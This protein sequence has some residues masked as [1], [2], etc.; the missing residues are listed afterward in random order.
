MTRRF[1]EQLS[2]LKVIIVVG[3]ACLAA[4]PLMCRRRPQDEHRV[5]VKLWIHGQPE[6]TKLLER[7]AALFEQKHPNID[8]KIETQVSRGWVDKYLAAMQ[9]KSCGDVLYV[10]WK[11]VPEFASKN[12]LVPL[13][14]L[15]RRD[16]YDLDAFFPGS[17]DAYRYGEGLYAIPCLGSTMVMFYNKDLFDEAGLD[18]PNDEWTWDDFLTAAKKL[19]II[20]EH[21][22][23][24]QVGC[25][26]YDPAT[27]IWSAGGRFASDDCSEL[28]LTDPKTIAGLQFYVDLKNKHKV[29]TRGMG[30]FG[31][32]P[33]AVDVFE[34]GRIAMD[35]NGPW[36]LTKYAPIKQFKWDVALFPKGPAGRHT[37]YAGMGFAIWSGSKKQ[38]LA[39]ELVKFMCGPQSSM[40][41]ADTLADV[42]ARKEAA[43]SPVFLKK[44]YPWDQTAFLRSQEAQYATIR[45][46][47]QSVRWPSV[48]RYFTDEGDLILSGVKTVEQGMADAESSARQLVVPPASLGDYVAMSVMGAMM[49]GLIGWRIMRRSSRTVQLRQAG[50]IARIPARR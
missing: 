29:T 8:V 44:E 41:L 36:M 16:N 9:A 12:S 24:K 23:I 48:Y 26:P 45:T 7:A 3:L 30:F 46:F 20:D 27:W 5:I 39:W 1:F 10:H 40:I 50:R 21:G 18:Y 28:Y 31:D 2:V 15:A 6:S 14:E 33:A 47:P 38:Q 32:D 17:V 37:R 49:L 34:K 13:E 4:S 22:R 42:P 35:I 11:R 25:G 43:Y 19:T